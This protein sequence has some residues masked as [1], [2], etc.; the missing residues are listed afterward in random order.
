M[1]KTILKYACVST[2]A[3]CTV[4]CDAKSKQEKTSVSTTVINYSP[5]RL[6]HLEIEGNST[7]TTIL[8][9]PRLG[10]N[11]TSGTRC[12][13]TVSKADFVT[14]TFDADYGDGTKHHTLKVPTEN[15]NDKM[16][17]DAVLHFLPNKTAVLEFTM[18]F[19]HPR[20]DLLYKATDKK[21]EEIDLDVPEWWKDKTGNE[22]ARE[23]YPD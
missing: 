16:N 21:L 9:S 11:A 14:I 18:R 8:P 15:V 19:P 13:A 4:G 7:E 23:E 5:Y 6:E 10:D 3:L 1:F 12:C 17:S 20:K 22:L 2:V